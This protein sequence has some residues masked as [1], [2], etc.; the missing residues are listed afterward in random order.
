MSLKLKVIIGAI[1]ASLACVTFAVAAPSWTNEFSLVPLVD[2]TYTLGTTTR[3]WLNL[4]TDQ[5]C[6]NGDCQTSWAG[7]SADGT[8]STT[9]ANYWSTFGLAFSTTSTNY[10]E[11]QQAA[12]GADGTFSTTSANYWSTF[13]LA[14]STTS[15]NYWKTQNTFEALTAGD[16]LTRTGD[17]FDFDGGATPS[18]DLGGTWASP[19][20]TDNSHN[21]D[22]TT[23]SGLGTADISGL[24]ISDDTNLASTYPIILTGDT[25]SFPATSTLFANLGTGILFNSAGTVT[26]STTL[27]L[28][29]IPT[30]LL[31]TGSAALCDGD[32]AS[33]AGGSAWPFTPSSYSGVANQS[34]TTPFWLNGTQLIASTTLVVNATST[35]LHVRQLTAALAL[36]DANSWAT[37]YAGS[38]CTNQFPRSV[39]AV[40]AWTCSTVD[41]G[42]DTNLTAGVG[43]TLTGDDV[44]CDTG[45]ASVF[46][47]LPSAD[48]V[49][50]SNKVGT[51]SVPTLGHL[52][53]WGGTAAIPALNS[54]ATSS[55]AASSAFSHSGTLG[56]LV[57][58]TGG[59]LSSV[60]T[61]AFTFATSTWAGTTTIPLGPAY[62]AETWNNV[63][64][65][66]DVGTL[67]IAF[68]DGTN[69]MNYFQASTTVGTITLS[70]NNSYT[71]SEKRYVK[72]GNPASSPTTISCTVNK[73]I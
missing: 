38:S 5:I 54:V 34:T 17:D 16:G 10:W 72:I 18:G 71:A 70:T 63:K 40:G 9:S 47:C 11:T 27:G 52:A 51:S 35:S 48:W 44:F 41:I 55:L 69:V 65:F 28:D 64:C 2:S 15:T 36:F 66:T 22:S 3:T 73:T 50:F 7:G 12:R 59:T 56:A 29:R 6:L 31:I 30:C 45:T 23:I 53:Y 68:D 60:Q 25:L 32:D 1:I 49:T 8:F 37:E 58:G 42:S 19:S 61:P 67:W 46:G 13:G 57:G 14:F 24:D 26:A 21:H 39:S 43:L 62:F 20:V 4:Y 33:G